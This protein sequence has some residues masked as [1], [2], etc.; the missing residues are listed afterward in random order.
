MSAKVSVI[1]P[2][3][4]RVAV[5]REA[6]ESVLAQTHRDLEVVVVDDGSTDATPELVAAFAAGDAR[7]RYERQANAGAAAARNTGLAAASGDFV[8]FLDSDDSWV[9]WHLSLMLAGLERYP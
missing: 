1:V 6:V 5:L 2:T 3:F 7:V 4:D 8:A 9:P